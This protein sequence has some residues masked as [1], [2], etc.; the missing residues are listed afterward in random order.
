MEREVLRKRG[1]YHMNWKV[2]LAMGHGP[3]EWM[4]LRFFAKKFTF[5]T[6]KK[7][8]VMWKTTAQ[9]GTRSLIHTH[10]LL[11]VSLAGNKS[12][13]RSQLLH[14]RLTNEITGLEKTHLNSEGSS[15][16]CFGEWLNI[17]LWN[18]WHALA[19]SV[20]CTLLVPLSVCS[21]FPGGHQP[22]TSASVETRSFTNNKSWLWIMLPQP[23]FIRIWN[24]RSDILDQTWKASSWW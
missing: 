7:T 4:V 6:K 22:R 24:Q 2:F 18:R 20:L 23:F 10:K 3:F 9:N 13:W 16:R 19:F 14:V 17:C 12:Q 21:C 15:V 11:E 8:E 5:V 1:L